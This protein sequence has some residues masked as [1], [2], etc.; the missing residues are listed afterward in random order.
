MFVKMLCLRADFIQSTGFNSNT[1]S[2]RM[3]EK[4]KQALQLL[5]CL[6]H[7]NCFVLLLLLVIASLF[8]CLVPFSD[9]SKD[10]KTLKVMQA[11]ESNFTV[12]MNIDD[13]GD[14]FLS[15]LT[16]KQASIKVIYN[17]SHIM[18]KATIISKHFK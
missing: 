14:W 6:C 10:L 1:K 4:Q 16:N 3:N 2:R 13:N 7:Y 12:K 9:R 17:A 5:M 18:I 8:N 15:Q 11:A